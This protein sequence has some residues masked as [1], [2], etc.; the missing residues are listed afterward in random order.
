MSGQLI[1]IPTPIDDENILPD[2]TKQFI[3][4]AL[5]QGAYVLVEEEKACRRRWLRYGLPRETIDKFI[6]FNEHTYKGLETELLKKMKSGNTLLLMSD[7]GLPAFCDPG[8]DLVSACHNQG[9]KVSAT[10]FSNSISLAIALSGFSH[11]RFIFEGFIPVKKTERSD[12]LKRIC[13]QR[14]VSVLM[15]TP[16]RFNRLLDELAEINKTQSLNR[17]VFVGINLN[18]KNELLLRGSISD[19]ITKAPKEKCE[20]V[21]LLGPKL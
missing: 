8:K 5:A 10:A 20:F 18:H 2:D 16:Y 17:E 1:L 12:N 7:C 21:L 15:D 19:I 14:E 6:L 3:M 11:D 13:K 9:L 4:N